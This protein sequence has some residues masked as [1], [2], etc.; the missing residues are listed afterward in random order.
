MTD[1]LTTGLAWVAGLGLPQVLLWVLTFAVVFE[2]LVKTRIFSRAPAALVS[3]IT[4]LFVLMAV[5]NAVVQVIAGLSTGLVTLVTGLIALVA[6]LEVAGAKHPVYSADGKNVVDYAPY[7]TGHKSVVAIVMLVLA[8]LIFA[9]S[10]GLGLIGITALP[11]IGMTTWVLIVIGVAVLW[12][13]S[14]SGKQ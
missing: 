10:G 4:G 2:V 12:M 8:G 14:E 13:I 1:G 6:L 11:A 7:L 5:P 9:V 3:V